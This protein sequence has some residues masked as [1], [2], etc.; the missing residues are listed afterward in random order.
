MPRLF[1]VQ[2]SNKHQIAHE[3]FIHE[4]IL[5]RQPA[6]DQLCCGLE[7]LGFLSLIRALPGV[8]KSCF[9]YE[10]QCLTADRLVSILKLPNSTPVESTASKPLIEVLQDLTDEGKYREM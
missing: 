10:A 1:F 4:A 9:T 5:R 3:F 7:S 6:I 2:L 8:M